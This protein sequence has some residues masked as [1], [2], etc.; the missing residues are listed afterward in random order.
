MTFTLRANGLSAPSP[1]AGE[2]WGAGCLV[3]ESV[4]IRT[5]LPPQLRSVDLPLKGGGD[6]KASEA[7]S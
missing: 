3:F 2:G 5:P 6:K 4:H 1:L 7:S